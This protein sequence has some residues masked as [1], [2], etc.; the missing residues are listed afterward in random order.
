M[1]D[2][3][4]KFFILLS[5]T[6]VIPI[7]SINTSDKIVYYVG[8]FS[9]LIASLF[10]EKVREIKSKKIIYLTIGLIFNSL[11]IYKFHILYLGYSLRVMCALLTYV[12]I[13]QYT[14]K[15]KE[16]YKFISIGI[17]LN[18]VYLI[19]QKN[20]LYYL[21][22]PEAPSVAPG[23]LMSSS[24]RLSDLICIALPIINLWL[25]PF[26]IISSF[27]GDPQTSIL[28]ICFAFSLVL[29]PRK[30]ILFSIICFSAGVFYCWDTIFESLNC[31]YNLF[32]QVIKQC[33]PYWNTGIGIGNKVGVD[34]IHQSSRVCSSIIQFICCSGVIGVLWLGYICKTYIRYFN[35]S[36]ECLVILG[37]IVL[38]TVEYP[39]E[40]VRLWMIIISQC[41]FFEISLSN[42]DER[43]V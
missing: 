5:I 10:C 2:N 25:I 32:F 19:T 38:S 3:V 12:L 27:V 39:F 14:K 13:V 28:L 9:L 24:P 43:N 30:Y 33:L 17:S 16:I 40:I 4:L 6:N 22:L 37:L 34:N 35:K 20:G 8:V 11:L 18:L 41:A 21:L 15:P 23:G 29:L 42:G 26:A 1:F 7:G 36:K 31:R